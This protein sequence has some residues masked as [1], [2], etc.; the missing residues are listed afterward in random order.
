MVYT[1]TT[2]TIEGH[3]IISHGRVIW[4]EEK[5][6]T[7]DGAM[8]F[9]IE[10]LIEKADRSDY[11]AIVG[12]RHQVREKEDGVYFSVMGTMVKVD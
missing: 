6:Y 5:F 4:A 7:S 3:E 8:E 12:I 1:S 10:N 2:G 9:T 11:N